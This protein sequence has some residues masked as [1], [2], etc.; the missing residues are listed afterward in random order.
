MSTLNDEILREA[1]AHLNDWQGDRRGI[2]RTLPLSEAEHADLIERVKVVADAMHLRPELDRSDG[3]TLI[4]LEPVDGDQI[5]T[6]QV[7][8]AARV[9]AAYQDI[10]GAP[11]TSLPMRPVSRPWLRWRRS[12]RPLAD[13]TG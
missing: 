5:S 13:P 11:A 3:I 6:A 4:A 1:L 9:E 12:A 7:A 2:R 10:C 8:L